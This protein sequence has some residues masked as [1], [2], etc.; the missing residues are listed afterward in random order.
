MIAS[1]ARIRRAG[2]ETFMALALYLIGAPGS[3]KSAVFDA[4]TLTPAGPNFAVR[5]G[6]RIG[7]VKVP[8][9]RLEAL[10]D[11]YHP[12][13]YTPAEVLFTDVAPPGGEAIRFGAMTPLLVNADAF[14]LVIQAF[15][16][17]ARDGRP[18][19]AAAEMESVLL[20]LVVSDLEKIERRF[21]RAEQ[22][23]NRGQKMAEIERAVLMRCKERLDSGEPLLGLPLRED[24]EKQVRTYQFLSLKPLLAVVNVS[25]DRISGAEDADL[26]ALADRKGVELLPFCAPLEAEIA[27]L[28]AS[29]QAAFLGDYG[30]KEPARDRV[31]RAAYRTL[32]MISFFTVGEDEVRA[33]PIRE[34]TRAQAAAGKIHSDLERGFIRAETVASDALLAAG[35][36]AKCR[37]NATLRLEGKE[38]IVRDGE[39]LNIRF[40]A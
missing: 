8:D 32:R 7:A 35:S 1:A 21:E 2:K 18:L 14:V 9:A 38:Y 13:K 11:L 15:G 23:R 20:E 22:D 3:G 30:L 25:E 27:Q 39:V 10:R 34:G 12:K 28:D 33:W 26:R 5:G 29:A 4:L 24:E 6:N 16:E 19:N 40:S 17:T 36:V 31:L 37:D